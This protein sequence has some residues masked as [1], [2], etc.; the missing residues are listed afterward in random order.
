MGVEGIHDLFE[1]DWRRNTDSFNWIQ[2]EHMY[3]YIYILV[4]GDELQVNNANWNERTHFELDLRHRS[5]KWI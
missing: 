5:V 4:S 1:L 3:I 2:S